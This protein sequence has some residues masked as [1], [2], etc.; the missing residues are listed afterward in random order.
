MQQQ[1][2]QMTVDLSSTTGQESATPWVAAGPRTVMAHVYVFAVGWGAST[3][4]VLEVQ[5]LPLAAVNNGWVGG[6][7]GDGNGVPTGDEITSASAV[8]GWALVR[9]VAVSAGEAL[10][11][12]TKTAGLGGSIDT[13]AQVLVVMV[14]GI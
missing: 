5:S 4:A 13:R 3:K 11:V 2:Q 14:D 10:R 1:Q 6:T 9:E 7:G 8:D 12:K